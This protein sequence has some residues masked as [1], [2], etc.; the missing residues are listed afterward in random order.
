MLQSRLSHVNVLLN[1]QAIP[2]VQ[3][4]CAQNCWF[5]DR[6]KNPNKLTQTFPGSLLPE[7]CDNERE[8]KCA[9]PEANTEH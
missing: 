6:K 4:A 8:G 3:D 7:E 5:L 9:E 2:W 1:S